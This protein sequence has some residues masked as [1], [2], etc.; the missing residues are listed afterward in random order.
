MIKFKR[1]FFAL[2]FSFFFIF[3]ASSRPA[4]AGVTARVLTMDDLN[5]LEKITFY[6]SSQRNL[7]DISPGGTDSSQVG[8]YNFYSGG[9]VVSTEGGSVRAE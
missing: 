7:I 9:L 2:C 1:Y 4:Y 6:N 3:F 5:R 8:A